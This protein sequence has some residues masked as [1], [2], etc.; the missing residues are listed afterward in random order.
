MS[1]TD[2]VK[3]INHKEKKIILI[4]FSDLGGEHLMTLLEEYRKYLIEGGPNL[5]TLADV[6]KTNYTYEFHERGREIGLEFKEKM[7]K[8]AVIGM[9]GIK[10][11]FFI[12]YVQFTEQRDNTKMFENMQESLEWLTQD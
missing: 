9:T 1:L 4:D 8:T 2:R 5:L 10:K 11:I 7:K 6:T 3:W 12:S